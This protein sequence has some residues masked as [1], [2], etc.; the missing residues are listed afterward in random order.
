MAIIRSTPP[1]QQQLPSVEI[2]VDPTPLPR[3]EFENYIPDYSDIDGVINALKA[4]AK[5]HQDKPEELD[6]KMVKFYKILELLRNL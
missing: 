1:L 3:Q 5:L 2:T 6:P 4:S